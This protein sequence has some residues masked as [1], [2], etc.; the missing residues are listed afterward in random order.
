METLRQRTAISRSTLSRPMRLALEASLID[1][2]TVILDYGCGRGDDVQTLSAL[3]ITSYGWDPAFRPDGEKR[4]ADVVNLGYV[5]NV[6]E[7]ATERSETLRDA[8]RLARKVLIVSARLAL[9]AKGPKYNTYGD[10]CLTG[11]GTFQKFFEQHEL[12]HW[13]EGAIGV[14]GVAAAPG[15]FFVFRDDDLRQSYLACRYRRKRAVPVQRLSDALFDRHKDLLVPVIDFVTRRGRL[16]EPAE[17]D[18]TPRVQTIFGSL[19]RAFAVVRRVT[20][21]EQWEEIRRERSEDVLVYLGLQRFDGRPRFSDLPRDLQL[22]VKAFFGT[23]NHA[24][25]QADELLFS[26]G[27]LEAID[28]ACQATPCG[29]L[30]PEAL[31]V[32]VS[33]LPQLPPILRIYEGCASAY[34]GTVEGANLVKLNRRKAKVSYLSYPDFDSAPHPALLGSLTVSLGNLEVRYWDYSDSENPPILHRKE[35]FVLQDYPLRP[36]FERLTKQEERWGLYEDSTSIGTRE[37]WNRLL[38]EKGVQLR[39]HRLLRALPG[40]DLL[41]H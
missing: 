37:A 40:S 30:T 38:Q 7:D 12:R 11:R 34:I 24:C 13:I 4:E 32:H 6:I 31:Y 10:G 26:A 14:A 9:E 22:D 23:Y 2:S 27:K 16:P 21:H 8:W 39:G 19:A 18:E 5:A 25:K 15:V 41:K 36:K 1:E 29:K 17:L 28:S 33:A 35:E 3:G 20:G